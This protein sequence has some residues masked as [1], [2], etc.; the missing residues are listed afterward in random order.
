MQELP[1]QAEIAGDA[2]LAIAGDGEPD[3]RQMHSDLVRAP[4]LEPNLE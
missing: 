4:R 2:V 1:L 3:G